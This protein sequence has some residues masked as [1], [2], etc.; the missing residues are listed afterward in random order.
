MSSVRM[1]DG[2]LI[3]REAHRAL[4]DLKNL[5]DQATKEVRV[6]EREAVGLAIG[7][8]HEGNPLEALRAVAEALQSPTFETAIMQARAKTETAVAWHLGNFGAE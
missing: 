1:Q 7:S 5:V 6:A 8:S 4:L 2:A 3:T